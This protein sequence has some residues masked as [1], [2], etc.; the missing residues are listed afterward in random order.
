MECFTVRPDTTKHLM[1]CLIDVC[2]V[3]FPN[4]KMMSLHPK[5]DVIAELAFVS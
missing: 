1:I 5:D 3:F 2:T 4:H